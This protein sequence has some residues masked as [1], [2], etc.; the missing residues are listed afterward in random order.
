MQQWQVYFSS[1]LDCFY[2]LFFSNCRGKDFQTCAEYKWW[3]WAPL[4][5]ILE[6]MLS[7]FHCWISFLFK[8]PSFGFIDL[9]VVFEVSV[10]FISALILVIYF[11]LLT[12][13]FVCCSFS[14]CFLC[15]I[16]LFET[17]LVSLGK[18]VLLWTSLLEL[19]LLYPIGFG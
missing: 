10:S 19:L 11:L 5:L 9:S 8:E 18:L 6:E 15:K 1:N 16:K 14:S 12:L 2:F 13:S 17:F 7:A 4:L 3:E